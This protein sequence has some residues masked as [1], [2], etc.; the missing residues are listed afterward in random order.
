MFPTMIQNQQDHVTL[1][2][3]VMMLKTSQELIK[4][5]YIKIENCFSFYISNTSNITVLYGIKKT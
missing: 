3:G 4:L 5:K 1:T 2:T